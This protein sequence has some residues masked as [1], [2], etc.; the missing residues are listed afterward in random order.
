MTLD[1]KI[2]GKPDLGGKLGGNLG[3]QYLSKLIRG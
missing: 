3:D 2:E 1:G